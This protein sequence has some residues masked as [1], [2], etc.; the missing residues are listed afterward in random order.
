MNIRSSTQDTLN[1]DGP[2][3]QLRMAQCMNKLNGAMNYGPI[4]LANQQGVGFLHLPNNALQW[5]RRR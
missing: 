2:K 5:S 3:N 4:E 1:N